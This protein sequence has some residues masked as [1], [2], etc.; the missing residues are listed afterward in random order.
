M[1]PRISPVAVLGGGKEEE[2]EVVKEEDS[3]ILPLL[4]FR[5]FLPFPPPNGC[6][7]HLLMGAHCVCV[8]VCVCDASLPGKGP[9]LVTFVFSASKQEA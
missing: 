4:Y 6:C 7:L 3:H 1:F 8:C 2:E 9:K 5:L